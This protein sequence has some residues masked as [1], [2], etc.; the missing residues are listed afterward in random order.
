MSSR[1]AHALDTGVVRLPESGEIV[2]FGGGADDTLMALPSDRTRVVQRFFPDH[3]AI[4][5]FGYDA[6]E[7][8]EGTFAM[9]VVRLP[10]NRHAARGRIAAARE[11]TKGPIVVDGAKTDGIEGILKELRKR[12]EVGAPLS[13]AHGKLFVVNGGEFSDWRAEPITVDGY[14]TVPGV[15][16]A[17]GIDRGS[18]LL[19]EALP[20]NL[21]GRIADLGA[22]WGYLANA[23]LASPDVTCVDLIEA[24]AD[25][26]DCARTNVTDARA[27]FHWADATEFK[28][29]KPYDA[30][31]M[32]PPFHVGR[33]A[34]PD[35]GR[36]FLRAAH[37]LL[38]RH[39]VLWLVANRHLPYERTLDELFAEVDDIGGDPG[40]KLYRAARPRRPKRS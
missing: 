14:V 9:A 26:L 1:L 10:R 29:D 19:A 6:V 13:K 39:G 38:G 8:P 30:V 35:I 17:D 22:G 27:R 28:T 11:V 3:A 34:D 16:S 37:H 7:A 40:F 5:R 25:A 15:F 31:V 2:V 36:A 12:A 24:D 4:R 33:R 21:K 32:N 18:R 23:V 20:G